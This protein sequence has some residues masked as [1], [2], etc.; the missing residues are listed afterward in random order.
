MIFPL[1]KI[2]CRVLR[3]ESEPRTS[4][5]HQNQPAP[6]QQVATAA[7]E[8]TLWTQALHHGGTVTSIWPQMCGLVAAHTRRQRELIICAARPEN[9][10]GGSVFRRG[11]VGRR[12][13][14]VAGRSDRTPARPRRHSDGGMEGGAQVKESTVISFMIDLPEIIYMQGFRERKMLH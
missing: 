6:H 13:G 5:S 10:S 4:L 2:K 7:T 8:E 9:G 1:H 14:R 3:S 11:S 12:R